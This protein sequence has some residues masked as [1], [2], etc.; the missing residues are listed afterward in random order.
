MNSE[1]EIETI[2]IDLL[3]E[4]VYRVYGYDFRSYARASIERRTRLFLSDNGYE[5]ISEILGKVI[6]DHRFFSRLVQYFSIPV[7]EMFRDPHVYRVLRNKVVPMLR[8]WPHVK[9]WQAGCATGEEVY[10]LAIVLKEEGL[11]D[12]TT[13]YATDFNDASLERAQEGIYEMDRIQVATRNYQKA[14]GCASFSNYYHALYDAAVMDASL[15][16]RITFANHNLVTDHAFGEMHLIAC[17]NVL[18]Y[19]DQ[20]LQN[21]VLHLFSES[22]V[23]GGFLCIGTKESLSFS[24]VV[25]AYRVV[26][27]KARIYRKKI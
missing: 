21:R 25:H 15:R 22:L 27:E 11:Y 5:T 23:H 26:D 2:E 8:T 10:S 13:L 20:T 17:R 7:T 18:I 9:I 3:L 12:R 6:R 14:G 19:F 4:A 24:E 1:T 16:E